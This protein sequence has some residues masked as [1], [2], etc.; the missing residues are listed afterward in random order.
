[1]TFGHM[2]LIS[3]IRVLHL[4]YRYRIVCL[5]E[6]QFI[7]ILE[8]LSHSSQRTTLK[9]ILKVIHL[10]GK[11]IFPFKC[12]SYILIKLRMSVDYQIQQREYM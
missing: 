1:M 5:D 6:M 10:Q 7:L 12:C 11:S 4:T 9:F 2:G 3:I 8:A